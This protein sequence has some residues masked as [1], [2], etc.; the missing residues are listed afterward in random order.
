MEYRR[1]GKT[2]LEVSN[3]GFGASSVGGMFEETSEDEGIQA[4]RTA[5]DR[6]ITYFDTS[7]AYGR[8]SSP[9]GPASSEIILGKGLSGISRAEFVLSTKVGK[10][11]SLPPELDFRYDSI[12]K[13]VESSLGRLNVEYLDIAILHD[14]E[15]DKGSHLEVAL[16]EGLN[17]LQD[18]KKEGKIRYFGASCYAIP[19]LEQ[20][21]GNVPLD[22]VLIHNHY[23]LIDNQLLQLLD[24]IIENGI[25]LVNASPFA[26]GLL[27]MQG[28]PDWFPIDDEGR[29]TVQQVIDYCHDKKVRIEQLALQYSIANDS[30]PTTLFSCST[31]EIVNQNINWSEE[32]L[33]DELMTK[34]KGLLS[35]IH[36]R[37][38]DFGGYNH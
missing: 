12:V 9:Y 18:L 31:K 13:S 27:T 3:L 6:G 14:I 36:N 32:S 35:A 8:P 17:A 11:S 29:E 25:G 16:S 22:I 20:I 7:P 2:D 4:I 34:V 33:N 37:D 28:P 23:N 5:F 30:L 10:L 15:Y 21:M 24:P 1:L 19:V 38:F 26:S